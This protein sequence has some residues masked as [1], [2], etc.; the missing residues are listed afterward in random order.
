ME[1]QLFDIKNCPFWSYKTLRHVGTCIVDGQNIKMKFTISINTPTRVPDALSIEAFCKEMT[2][3]K[4]TLE[5]YTAKLAAF[6]KPL[7]SKFQTTTATVTGKGKTPTH[8]LI[9]C[10]VE[11]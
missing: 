2:A 6:L 5:G 11:V 1:I 10:T 9:T 7:S 3:E 8:G 4:D